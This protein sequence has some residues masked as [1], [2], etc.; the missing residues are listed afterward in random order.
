[1]EW[2]VLGPLV[3]FRRE[4]IRNVAQRAEDSPSTS[5]LFALMQ[6][7][8]LRAKSRDFFF[9]LTQTHDLFFLRDQV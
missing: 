9:S 8:N 1:V 3:W 5:D 4:T 2:D 7:L 6:L